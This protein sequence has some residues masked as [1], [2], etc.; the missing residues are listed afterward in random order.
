MMRVS[1]IPGPG[2][3]AG[4]VM[5]AL[6]CSLVP[7]MVLPTGA[8]A[9]CPVQGSPVV[10]LGFHESYP[11]SD[12]AVTHLGVDLLADGGSPVSAPCDG[13]VS[14]VGDVPASEPGDGRT[15]LAV[16]LMREDGLTLTMMPFESASVTEGQ[17][18]R[19]GMAVGALAAGGDRSV[20]SPHLHVGLKE[21]SRY[22]D[23]LPLLGVAEGTTSRCDETDAQRAVADDAG[24]RM[25]EDPVA[26]QDPWSVTSDDVDEMLMGDVPGEALVL[27]QERLDATCPDG[28]VAE[29]SGCG[30]ALPE[31]SPQGLVT[32][33]GA[34]L[35]TVPSGEAPW[36]QVAWAAVTGHL[37]GL[38]TD[39]MDLL[40][41][42]LGLGHRV[43]A[44]GIL[45][46]MVLVLTVL[47][48]SVPAALR[49]RHRLE[50]RS[51]RGR[52]GPARVSGASITGR[53]EEKARVFA[54]SVGQ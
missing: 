19:D 16:S 8:H 4:K 14:F 41:C 5:T 45:A 1:G 7:V 36:W 24:V 48:A 40:T 23:P 53:G 30:T 38:A 31:G 26:V 21:G 20:A 37:E 22:L 17:Q 15:M 29:G 33:A 10:A 39:M 13:T 6:L 44:G 12:H 18:V 28:G 50:R 42:E 27:S 49:C 34:S 47:G 35:D 43:P 2:I 25:G 52:R 46:V 3:V 54:E 11:A 32:S 9:S 51:A